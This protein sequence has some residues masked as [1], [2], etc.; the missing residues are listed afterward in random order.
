RGRSAILARPATTGTTF[1]KPASKTTMAA[2]TV[3][4]TVAALTAEMAAPEAA[5]P[6]VGM[7]VREADQ[8]EIQAA[9]AAGAEAAIVEVE[10]AG[11]AQAEAAVVEEVATTGRPNLHRLPVITRQRSN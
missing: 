8:V 4:E 5:V 9:E 10:P 11:A 6:V 1:C 3:V 7:A 2:A